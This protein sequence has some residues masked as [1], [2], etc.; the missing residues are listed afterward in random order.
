MR[1]IWAMTTLS[2]LHVGVLTRDA[3]GQF[4]AEPSIT[5]GGISCPYGVGVG[6][7]NNDGRADLAV[8]S[9]VRNANGKGYDGAKSR[10]LIL[11]QSDRGFGLPPDRE[12]AATNPVGLLIRGTRPHAR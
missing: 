7:L 8:T 6:D 10:V 5:I 1:A 9:W 12:L 4:P 11:L 3:Q 2:L